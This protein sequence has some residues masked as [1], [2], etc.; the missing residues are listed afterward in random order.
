MDD[1]RPREIAADLRELREALGEM[2]FP[3]EPVDVVV[4]LVHHRASP[5]LVGRVRALSPTRPYRSLDE[6]CA[7]VDGYP[8]ARIPP[9][10]A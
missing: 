3:A 5:R 9:P 6:L 10:W 4:E 8:P 2:S 7:H 1:V